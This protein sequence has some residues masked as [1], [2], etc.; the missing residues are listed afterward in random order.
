MNIGLRLS[1]RGNVKDYSNQQKEAVIRFVESI[2]SDEGELQLPQKS[3]LERAFANL[4]N[5]FNYSLIYREDS[6]RKE[7]E[8]LKKV[9]LAIRQLSREGKEP[10]IKDIARI[11]RKNRWSL[12][13][14]M[15]KYKIYDPET[16]KITNYFDEWHRFNKNPNFGMENTSGEE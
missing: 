7:T 1:V 15:V 5:H 8:V 3:D 4:L 10:C 6:K 16:R 9:T 13:Q 11:V 14:L 12:R 2:F